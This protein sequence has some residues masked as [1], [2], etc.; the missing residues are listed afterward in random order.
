MQFDAADMSVYELVSTGSVKD[1]LVNSRFT[2]NNRP[3]ID[4]PSG[5]RIVD[6]AQCTHGV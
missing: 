6:S 2:I 5:F 1:P 4:N 3:T